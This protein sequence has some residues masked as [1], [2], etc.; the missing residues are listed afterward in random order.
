MTTRQHTDQ[1]ALLDFGHS[2]ADVVPMHKPRWTPDEH[3][4][5]AATGGRVR[6]G[7]LPPN[8]RGWLVAQLTHA[9]HTTDTI[10]EW[11]G[12]SR[13]TIQNVRG[14]PTAVLTMMLL[15]AEQAIE[16]AGHKARV[17]TVPPAAI[18]D[19]TREN[20]RLRTARNTLIDQ[21]A[22]MRKLADQP[23]PPQIVIIHPPRRRAARPPQ[24]TLP[25]F[26]VRA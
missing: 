21:L 20:E 10:A 8:E 7:D 23:C 26:E 12:C 6:L 2:V 17:A 13:R 24:L 5:D 22:A 9:G 15:D 1:M 18:I 3:L 16:Q 14:E 11:L 25:L 19:L 4:I